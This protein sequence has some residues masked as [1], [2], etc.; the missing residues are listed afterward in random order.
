VMMAA[1]FVTIHIEVTNNVPL[2]YNAN[3]DF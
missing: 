3:Y 2:S 1:L